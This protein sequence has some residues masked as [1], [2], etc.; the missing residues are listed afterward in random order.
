MPPR[1]GSAQRAPAH[2]S[3]TGAADA[4][5]TDRD[6]VELLSQA[7]RDGDLAL[8]RAL[9]DDGA[10]ASEADSECVTP[11]H[12]AAYYN[13]PRMIHL[14]VAR[15]AL[16]N[17]PSCLKATNGYTALVYAARNGKLAAVKALLEH[18]ANTELPPERTPL[19]AAAGFGHTEVVEALI[20]ADANV[21]AWQNGLLP[22][23]VAL[24]GGMVDTAKL[25]VKWELLMVVEYLRRAAH[26]AAD[27]CECQGSP[28]AQKVAP[29]LEV[30]KTVGRTDSLESFRSFAQSALQLAESAEFIAAGA[31]WNASDNMRALLTC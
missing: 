13:R 1:S 2:G 31:E 23:A 10:D 17:R 3:H 8:A 6:A 14:L 16:V 11:L 27:E 28:A 24:K 7:A 5:A 26:A 12:W 9:L 22:H 25:L 19:H 4:R 18:K 20:D 21:L 15:G 29:L 30:S